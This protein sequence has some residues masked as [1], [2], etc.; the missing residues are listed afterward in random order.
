MTLDPIN[1]FVVPHFET[2]MMKPLQPFRHQEHRQLYV[3]VDDTTSQFER[4]VDYV[5]R[6][7]MPLDSGQLI[8]VTGDT[9]CGKSA[10]VNRCADH[11]AKV[12]A[13]L[14]ESIDC[15]IIDL[16]AALQSDRQLSAPARM[17]QVRDQF[18]FELRDRDLIPEARLAELTRA[19]YPGTGSYRA[20]SRWL[21]ERKAVVALLPDTDLPPELIGYAKAAGAGPGLFFFVESAY[22]DEKAVD[23]V[24]RGVEDWTTPLH[25]HVGP[26]RTGDVARFTKDRLARNTQRGR[27]PR[28][29]DET[30][31]S[32]EDDFASIAELQRALQRTYQHR[33][34]LRL[35][36][37]DD[38][39][40]TR[41]DIVAAGWT[42]VGS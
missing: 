19:P 10:L 41:S 27:Y 6:L 40:I 5:N 23:Q 34:D 39:R 30:I 14:E 2:R 36:Y 11:L 28:L 22:L 24:V 32:I 17:E 26:L 25:L 31:E 33:L 16:T 29:S 35:S 8:L 18:L 37:E 21:R 1:P 15:P 13:G 38:D 4:F 9:G 7:P 3:E 12:L 42:G 20:I